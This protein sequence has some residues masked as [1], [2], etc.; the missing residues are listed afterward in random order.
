MG[1]GS[2]EGYTIDLDSFHQTTNKN[3][4]SMRKIALPKN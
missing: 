1:L 2:L 4:K 3:L